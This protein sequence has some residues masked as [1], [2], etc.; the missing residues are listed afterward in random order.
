MKKYIEVFEDFESSRDDVIFL[1]LDEVPISFDLATD[2]SYSF[3]GEKEVAGLT[4]ANNKTRATATLCISSDGQI[5]PPLINFI[6]KY[7]ADSARTN[8][9]KFDEKMNITKPYMVRFSES[10]FNKDSHLKEYIDKVILPWRANMT[11]ELVLLLDQAPC[12]I[13][14]DLTSYLDSIRMTYLFIPSGGT[15]IFQPLDVMI[16]KPFKDKLREFY[17][18]WLERQVSQENVKVVTPPQPA[19]ILDWIVGGLKEIDSLLVQDSFKVTGVLDTLAG[20]YIEEKLT[21][22]LSTI[23]EMYLNEEEREYLNEIDRLL[24]NYYVEQELTISN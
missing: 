6:Y 5:L 19:I 18:S 8:P 11:K 1:N 23:Y 13:S 17:L 16:N 3:Q 7:A 22:K 2:Y 4:H 15:H 21:D 24:E 9:K 20:N 14:K 10:G 12:H